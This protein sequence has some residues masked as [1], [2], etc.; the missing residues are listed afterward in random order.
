MAAAGVLDK[1]TA[2]RDILAERHA[3][4]PAQMHGE[5]LKERAQMLRPTG[6]NGA[7][8]IYV[9]TMLA[10]G[11]RE[12]D[13]AKTLAA[14]AA[15]GSTIVA[16]DSGISVAPDAGA[17]GVS[18]ALEDWARAKRSAQTA[19]GRLLGVQAAAAAKRERTM[20]QVR[21][22]RPLWRDTSPGRMTTEQVAAEAKLSIKTL[23]SELGR[24]PAMKKGRS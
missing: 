4:R 14:A 6:R 3:K 18:A 10:L 12:A 16:L 1:G 22:A 17:Y 19:P 2:Y 24:R 13:L 15:R 7:D 21:I 20:R 9:A 5:W 8:T 11:V 23:Y